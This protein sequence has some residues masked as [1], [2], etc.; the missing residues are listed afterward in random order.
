MYP[1][2]CSCYITD[3][4][5]CSTCICCYNNT[6]PSNFLYSDGGTSFLN[7]ETMTIVDVRLSRTELR[8]KVTKPITQRRVCGLRVV[9][10]LVTSLN[11]Q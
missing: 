11:P 5:P 1:K 4:S 9:I 6:A 8:A 3:R 2:H 10:L 7:K